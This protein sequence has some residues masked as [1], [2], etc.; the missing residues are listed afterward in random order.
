MDLRLLRWVG[1]NSRRRAVRRRRGEGGRCVRR[2]ASSSAHHWAGSRPGRSSGRRCW[3]QLRQVSQPDSAGVRG[4]LVGLVVAVVASVVGGR[5]RCGEVGDSRGLLVAP[6]SPGASD[7]IL[8]G[9][10]KCEPSA[11]VERAACT[12]TEAGSPS[13]LVLGSWDSGSLSAAEKA[14]F[15]R[16]YDFIWARFLQVDPN[17]ERLGSWRNFGVCL[18]PARLGNFRLLCV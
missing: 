3:R 18:W 14:C 8:L 9:S 16:L 5:L 13:V 2:R 1:W 11:G 12:A 7:R 4:D 10:R 6:S 17:F 15:S